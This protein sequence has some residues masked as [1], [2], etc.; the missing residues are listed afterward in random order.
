MI[1]SAARASPPSILRRPI[2]AV[3]A[4][5][6]W[7][8]WRMGRSLGRNIGFEMNTVA[9]L[10]VASVAGPQYTVGMKWIVQNPDILGGQ[11]RVNG[12]R[13]S[14]SFVI[15]CISE[16]MTASEIAQDYPGFPPEALP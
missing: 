9:R 7:W 2:M 4:R 10:L 15:Q 1:S 3:T 12:T 6:R 8:S 11:P 5:A 16:G 13:L 14:V